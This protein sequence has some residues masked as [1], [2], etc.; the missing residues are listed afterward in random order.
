MSNL[1]RPKKPLQQ[2]MLEGGRIRADKGEDI[3]GVQVPLV[4][5]PCPQ[6]MGKL[7]RKHW[8]T[9]GPELVSAGLLSKVDGD[10]FAMHCD[11][12]TSYGEVRKKLEK[13]D[14][15]ISTTPNGF[16]VQAAYLQILNKL[17][18][19]IIKTAR[20]FGLTPASRSGMKV[21]IAEQGSL[22]GNNE[23]NEFGGS[24]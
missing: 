4:M 16:E 10:V 11:D 6:W 23:W 2:K 22:F 17:H 21:T 1:G 5:P 8:E 9:L 18:D 7:A 19:R 13:L 15:W 12:V 14:D 24:A 3:N 20:E